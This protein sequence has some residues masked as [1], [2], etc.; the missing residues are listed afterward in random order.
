MFGRRFDQARAQGLRIVNYVSLFFGVLFTITI[1]LQFVNNPTGQISAFGMFLLALTGGLSLW[2]QRQRQATLASL[3]NVYGTILALFFFYLPFGINHVG[4]LV[5]AFPIV[6]AGVLLGGRAVL[7]TAV[8]II[9]SGIALHYIDFFKAPIQT[10][11]F[12]IPDQENIAPVITIAAGILAYT[13]LIYAMIQRQ[14][15]ALT[16]IVEEARNLEAITGLSTLINAQPTLDSLLT[17]AVDALRDR[18]DYY[19]VQVYLIDPDSNQLI[20]QALTR[21]GRR[22]SIERRIG[23]YDA[24]NVIALTSRAGTTQQISLDAPESK[25]TEFLP[26]T[27]HELLIPLKHRDQALG[28]LDV[29]SIQTTPFSEYQ[30]IVLEAYAAQ[31]SMAILAFQREAELGE[32]NADRRRLLDQ[33]TRLNR[34]VDRLTQEVTDRAWT[35]YLANRPG[36]IVGYDWDSGTTSPATEINDSLQQ[37]YGN[38]MPSVVNEGDEQVLGVPIMARG[39]VIGV[40]EFRAPVATPWDSRSLE[41]ARTIAQRLSLTLDNIRLFEQAQINA[42]REY[43]INQVASRLQTKI[44]LD[45]LL[46]DAAEAFNQ[47]VGGTQTRIKLITPDQIGDRN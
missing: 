40:M 27:R 35:R 5:M 7:L 47:A 26:A 28:V 45:T 24:Q 12:I 43:M 34:E 11:P 10:I 32:T 36:G 31:L 3:I 2:A 41:L 42:S 1:L 33:S 39:R 46:H 37:I 15:D 29:H 16:G 19:F 30:Q 6:M 9:I 8:T 18:L 17:E 38:A 4:A 21:I 44:D 13:G 14:Q 20:R 25:R 23:V 22:S